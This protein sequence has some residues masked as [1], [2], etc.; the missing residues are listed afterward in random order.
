M[1][2]LETFQKLK[3][4]AELVES[5]ARGD[6]R[7]AVVRLKRRT[8]Q[9]YCKSV[10]GN[11]PQPHSGAFCFFSVQFVDDREFLLSIFLFSGTA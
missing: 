3:R 8:A 6:S 5:K 2:A 1:A 10:L 4:Q 7:G 9:M 11:N